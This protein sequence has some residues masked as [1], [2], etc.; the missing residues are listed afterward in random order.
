[1]IDLF[2]RIKIISRLVLL[3]GCNWIYDFIFIVIKGQRITKEIIKIKSG[4]LIVVIAD[5]IL[6]RV[7]KIVHGLEKSGCNTVLLF[8]YEKG[9]H[10]DIF[11]ISFQYK[12]KLGALWLAYKFKPIAYHVF[13]SWN[14]DTAYAL[15]S[16]KHKLGK[17]VFDDYDVFAGMVNEG[18]AN[19]HFP[20][21]Y[22]KE[23]YCLENA[24]GICCRSLET[25]Y[26]MQKLRYKYKGKR[27]FF[28]EYMWEQKNYA[29]KYTSKR[30]TIVYAGNFDSNAR[31]V[32]IE[33]KKIGWNLE[34]F[35]TFGAKYNTQDLPDNMIIYKTV[36]FNELIA[37]LST[38][39]Y[40]IQIPIKM[41]VNYQKVYTSEKR[42]YS[43]AG[44]L[45]DYMEAG[46]KVIISDELFQKWIMQRYQF[47]ITV[48][49]NNPLQE[50]TTKLQDKNN[51]IE[52]DITMVKHLT[53][54][55]QIKRLINFYNTI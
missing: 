6:H 17:I 10:Q 19:K 18:Y 26:G 49:E 1:M 11:K 30:K 42:K 20:G 7:A 45:F 53:L 29:D 47:A 22:K 23:K 24:D 4:F 34:I 40:S 44:K 12:S 32:A 27:I 8:K 14:F 35:P 28:P 13:S 48:N 38:Y 5:K 33:L 21:Q 50:I 54:K 41:K 37:T 15:I 55:S 16:K 52:A 3:D 46:L 43:I 9:F 39:Y 25:Q 31:L 51:L 2:K 36:P